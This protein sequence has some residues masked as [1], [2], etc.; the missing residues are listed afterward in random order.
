MVK[1]QNFNELIEHDFVRLTAEVK[2]KREHPETKDLSDREVVK[3]SVESLAQAVPLGVTPPPTSPV[4]NDADDHVTSDI[5]P[6]YLA[7][8]SD[9][10]QAQH[11]VK[12]LIDF[13]FHEGLE[14]AIRES[15]KRSPFVVDAFHD[16]LV[17]KMLPEL[18][19]RGVI[20]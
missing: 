2:A 11:E 15:K 5:L 4:V 13:F 12:V 16:A 3:R 9:A 7:N 8:E 20:S 19:K 18:K 10:V 6:E 14:R 1:F 17:D